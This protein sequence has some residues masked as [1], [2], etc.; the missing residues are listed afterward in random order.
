VRGVLALDAFARCWVQELRLFAALTPLLA[1]DRRAAFVRLADAWRVRRW[2]QFDAAIAALAAPIAS[3]VCARIAVPPVAM[4]RRLGSALGVAAGDGARRQSDALGALVARLDAD[5]HAAMQKLLALHDL[6]GRAAAEVEARL[7]SDLAREGP[8]GEGKAAAVGGIVSG[9]VTG[10]AADLA[11]GGLTFGAGMLTGAIVGALGGAGVARAVN[12]A[13]GQ[14][15]DAV[16]WDDAFLDRLVTSSLLR[17]LAVAHYGR[18]RGDWRDSEYPSFWRERVRDALAPRRAEYT[19]IFAMRGPPC[20]VAR[21]EA[22]LR[23]LL[24]DTV[25]ALLAQLYPDASLEEA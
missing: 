20:D 22:S 1:A 4:L 12:V 25:R 10:L 23:P 7:A 19:A 18:G 14:T 21:I 6:E 24:A 11:A 15:E 9:A 5:L 13:R 2:A 8:L 16:R 3:A 17:Y